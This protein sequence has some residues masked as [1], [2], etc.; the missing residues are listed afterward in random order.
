MEYIVAPLLRNTEIPIRS[1]KDEQETTTI[2]K[3]EGWDAFFANVIR[4][5]R[6][7]IP[8]KF[9]FLAKSA[10]EYNIYLN[11]IDVNLKKL[12]GEKK[13][14]VWFN[15]LYANKINLDPNKVEFL[16]IGREKGFVLRMEAVKSLC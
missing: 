13:A 4:F 2:R 14:M 12:L 9:E 8:S 16:V 5:E 3:M 15:E 7:Q 6:I 1:D 10:K 11:K